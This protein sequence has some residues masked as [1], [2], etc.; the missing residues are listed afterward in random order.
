[1]FRSIAL[2]ALVAV[3]G[4]AAA[5]DAS[6]DP[7][8][9]VEVID[10]DVFRAL[11]EAHQVREIETTGRDQTMP[12]V[13]FR[14]PSGPFVNVILVNCRQVRELSQCRSLH[15]GVCWTAGEMRRAMPT[16]AEINTFNTD[17]LAGW[18]VVRQIGGRPAACVHHAQVLEGG[19][20][21]KSIAENIATLGS[22]VER[23]RTAFGL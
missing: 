19:V 17:A 8:R 22:M 21:L 18:A 5:E 6:Y 15:Y 12:R 9:I 13:S 16:A 11:L 2:A 20:R 3:A 7:E 4:P 14:D 23:F 10:V 1:M